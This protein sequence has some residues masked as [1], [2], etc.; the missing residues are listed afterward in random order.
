MILIHYLCQRITW[1]FVY[2][3]RLASI[4]FLFYFHFLV[5][6][7]F[8]FSFSSVVLHFLAVLHSCL[9]LWKPKKDFYFVVSSFL[10]LLRLFR[11]HQKHLFVLFVWFFSLRIF[12]SCLFSC[13]LVSLALIL[14]PLFICVSLLFVCRFLKTQNNKNIFSSYCYCIVVCRVQLMSTVALAL[15]YYFHIIR[16]CKRQ[17]NN[18]DIWWSGRD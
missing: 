6:F 5:A 7:F 15:Y 11:K 14:L 13:F 18:D 10:L 17:G 1:Y 8:S 2:S 12:S 4:Y 3:F 9:S 16:L